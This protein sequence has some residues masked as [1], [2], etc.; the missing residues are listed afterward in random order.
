V[1]NQGTYIDNELHEV[2]LVRRDVD[3]DSLLLQDGEVDDVNLVRE[4]PRQGL[5]PHAEEYAMMSSR[6]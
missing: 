1:L 2:F 5:V 6:A 3:V 4:L